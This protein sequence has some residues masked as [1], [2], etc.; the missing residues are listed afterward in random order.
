MADVERLIPEQQV[1]RCQRR[2]ELEGGVDGVCRDCQPDEGR[3]VA[4]ANLRR[5]EYRPKPRQLPEARTRAEGW[6]LV[7]DVEAHEVL[8]PRDGQAQAVELEADDA[9]WERER[10]VLWVKDPQP[11]DASQEGQV[12]RPRLRVHGHRGVGAGERERLVERAE[13]GDAQ[14]R[15]EDDA[16]PGTCGE[17]VLGADA[18]GD[19]VAEDVGCRGKAV[20]PDAQHFVERRQDEDHAPGKGKGR[21]ARGRGERRRVHLEGEGCS[22]A[23]RDKGERLDCC[24]V[25]GVEEYVGKVVRLEAYRH[26]RTSQRLNLVRERC[27][28]RI[29]KALSLKPPRGQK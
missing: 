2:G 7:L 25:V 13:P 9:G 27:R 16:D 21:I 20:C 11:P 6:A 17:E 19:G 3:H 8:R 24:N 15:R 12:K 4:E 29:T 14:A 18:F 28:A 1:Q 26:G 10:Q 23:P 5:G 22:A